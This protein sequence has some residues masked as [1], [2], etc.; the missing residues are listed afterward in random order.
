MSDRET[1]P[2]LL[3]ANGVHGRTGAY[4]VDSPGLT[5]FAAATRSAE[6]EADEA[7][8]AERRRAQIDA[9]VMRTIPGVD[10]GDLSQ[11]G[12][13]V[14]FS[15]ADAD[16]DLVEEIRRQLEPLFEHRR[17]AATAANP[18][19][20]RE[21][22]GADGYHEGQSA[23]G[24]LAGQ[25]VGADSADPEDM[26]VFLLI[27]GS[28]AQIPFSVQ[29]GIDMQRAVGRIHF[30]DLEDYGRY[31]A[32]VVAHETGGGAKPERR[33][34][35]FGPRNPGDTATGLSSSR[36]ITTL[37]DRLE[38]QP[39]WDVAT[40]QPKESTKQGLK[41]LF[42]DATPGALLFTAS[43]GI[44]FDLDDPLQLTDQGALVC[45]DWD[46]PGE[47]ISP[48]EYFAAID[49]PDNAA[50]AGR[51]AFL[52]ACYGG[53]TPASDDFAHRVSVTSS[54]DIAEEPFLARLPQKLLAG[55][56]LAVAAHVDRAWSYSFQWGKARTQ[57]RSFES[58]LRMLMSGDAIGVAFDHI[59]VKAGTLA[60]AQA[61]LLG[62]V[63]ADPNT[64]R[65]A[66]TTWTAA[67]DA[68][69]YIVIGDP[70]VR[71]AVT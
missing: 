26:P 46:G 4:L 3:A 54:I 32:A 5:E 41:G 67:V 12:W 55:G 48:D 21:Y 59:N 42:T 34:D 58:T 30:D 45:Q 38:N 62:D 19:L 6:T 43:H 37:A 10:E 29:Y 14:L 71:L 60:V 66:V 44:G 61:S 27:V 25:G 40:T 9:G 7:T 51:M 47:E 53:G 28:P 63:L 2:Q 11:T 16:Q 23:L 8:L 17:Q 22:L 39:Q 70:A 36:L 1:E 56:M 33:I 18:N 24:W 35:F 15:G 31:A 57:V 69:N 52:F 13:A 64:I 50:L 65:S 49:I 20:Y 68:R